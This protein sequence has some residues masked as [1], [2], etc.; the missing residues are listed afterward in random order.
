MA[1]QKIKIRTEI[2][3][4]ILEKSYA[5]KVFLITKKLSS[6]FLR[7][8][9]LITINLFEKRTKFLKAMKKK[10]A[11]NW[12]VGSVPSKS[13]STVFFLNEEG[14]ISK[15]TAQI[16]THEIAHLYTNKNNPNLPDWIKEGLSV[17]WAKQIFFQTINK[18]SWNKIAPTGVPFKQIKWPFA[19]EH[20]GYAIAG[21][22]VFFLIKKYGKKNFIET[23]ISFKREA[24]ILESF[25]RLSG[26]TQESL[27]KDFFD[28][29][30]K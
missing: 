14:K 16:L 9:D 27:S 1:Y 30:V 13:T 26:E 25:A 12:I 7:S 8:P 24:S 5:R 28:H 29:F 15:K 2:K 10:N 6:F 4:N 18:E 19:A 23:I 3:N 20:N 11:P 21:L 22:L 17:F